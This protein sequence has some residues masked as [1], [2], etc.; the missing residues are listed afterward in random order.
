[1]TGPGAVAPRAAGDLRSGTVGLPL[2]PPGVFRVVA[3]RWMTGRTAARCTGAGAAALLIGDVGAA[4]AADGPPV[5]IAGDGRCAAAGSEGA[6]CGEAGRGLTG[7]T[8][9]KA[10][11]PSSGAVCVGAVRGCG[12]GEGAAA[13]GADVVGLGAGVGADVGAST[14]RW[15]VG[16]SVAVPDVDDGPLAT[17][18][19]LTGC[20]GAPV[21]GVARTTGTLGVALLVGVGVGVGAG[22]TARWIG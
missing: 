17:G 3:L 19:T 14:E 8:A 13:A 21:P 18:S 15:I 4:A 7:I 5:G 11:A 10:R 2:P 9:W 22:A 16:R 6:D 12:V 20:C 1:M